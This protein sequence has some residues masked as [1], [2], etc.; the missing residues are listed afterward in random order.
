[1]AGMPAQTG[2]TGEF[3]NEWG[4]MPTRILMRSAVAAIAAAAAVA[5]PLRLGAQCTLG[6]ASQFAVL[7]AATL[8]NTGATTI[9]GDAGVYPGSSATGTASITLTGAY[10]ITDAV[11]QQ[12][13]IDANSAFICLAG[14]PFAFD[15][16]GQDLGG[17]T[18]TPGVYYFSSS[19][20]LTGPLTLDFLG[21]PGAVFDFEIGSTLTT[22]S[23]STVSILNG[24]PG[25]GLFWVVGSS[26]TLGTSTSFQGNIIADQSI[27]LTTGADIVC[28]RAIALVGAVTMDHNVISN[29]CANGGDIG[30]GRTDFGTGGFSALTPE[31]TSMMLFATGLMGLVGAGAWRRKR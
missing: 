27:T 16:S 29:D 22:A 24:A 6:T 10:H 30:T 20:Q 5:M 9:N 17:L 19:A 15:L 14:Q 25:D 18:L 1:M 12:A 21:N 3:V 8:T 23:G 11:A 26:A 13:G 28:G 31:P 2:S 4:W 7:G